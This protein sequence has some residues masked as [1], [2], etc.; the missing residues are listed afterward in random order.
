MDFAA[1]G[2]GG[3]GGDGTAAVAGVGGDALIEAGRTTGA[4]QIQRAVG[5]VVEHGE[6][7]QGAGR[8]HP[9]EVAER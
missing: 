4:A 3:A 5:M 1:V 9:D 6:V 8:R 2:G 7:V